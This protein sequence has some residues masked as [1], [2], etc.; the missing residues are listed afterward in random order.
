MPPTDALNIPSYGMLL[1]EHQAKIKT[2][3]VSFVIL[4]NE[5]PAGGLYIDQSCNGLFLCHRPSD[6]NNETRYIYNPSTR[7]YRMIPQ[8]PPFLEETN[9]S[10]F[11]WQFYLAFSPS[12]SLYYE[13]VFLWKNCRVNPHE[14]QMAVY[15][16][17]TGLWRLCGYVMLDFKVRTCRC[18]FWNGYLNWIGRGRT[19]YYFNI[20]KQVLK[21]SLLSDE[22]QKH[23]GVQDYFGE[24]TGHMYLML[25]EKVWPSNST[26]IFEME[27]DYSGWKPICQVELGGFANKNGMV[28]LSAYFRILKVVV[29]G[30]GDEDELKVLIL[31]PGKDKPGED[32][33]VCY[34]LKT[35]SFEEI[36]NCRMDQF[37]QYLQPAYIG[38]ISNV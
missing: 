7:H 38:S 17:N 3:A 31:L 19:L 16:S 10:S 15:S 14:H 32:K 13:I 33:I 23:W 27:I 4:Q 22:T 21:T 18:V 12:K 26:C 2:N 11:D 5:R 28:T 36:C 29:E 25:R 24:C 35:N 8:P 1:L 34:D 6:C 30:D 37:D 9:C 20:A